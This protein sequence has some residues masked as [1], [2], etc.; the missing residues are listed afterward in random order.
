[1]DGFPFFFPEK[2][3]FPRTLEFPFIFNGPFSAHLTRVAYPEGIAL[4]N[5]RISRH[6]KHFPSLFLPNV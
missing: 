2:T 3:R 1:M 6:A 5:Q 4:A